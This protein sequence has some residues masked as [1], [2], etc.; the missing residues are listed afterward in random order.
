MRNRWLTLAALVAGA[1][2]GAAAL[3]PASATDPV[4]LEAGYVTDIA[5]VLE[6]SE[7]QAAEDRLL[8]LSTESDASLFVVFVDE[9][10]SPSDRIAWADTVARDN[11]LGDEQYLLAVAVEQGVYYIS[12]GAGGPISDAQLDDIEQ[13]IQP[14]LSQSDWEGAVIL[15]ADE[16]QGD[17]GA[18]L[19]R[20]VLIVAGIV[21]AALV[22]WL[23]VR[24]II[25]A[26]RNAEIRRRGAMPE[27]P[28]PNDP[29][30]TLTDEQV[31]A[32]AGSAIVQADDAI[33]SS[34]E[35]LGFAVAQFGEGV[36]AQFSSVL[37]AAKAKM[38]EVFDLKQKLDD[39]IED[40]VH[41]RRAWHIRIIRLCDE[42]DEM[43]DQNTEAFDELRGLA[44]N[45]P[46]ELERVKRERAALQPLLDGAQPELQSLS[47]SYDADALSTVAEN[48]AQA[49]ERAV[50]AD[51][52]I[53]A[54]AS[55][56]EAGR[57]GEAAFAIRTAEQA[58]AQAA[59]LTRA[60]ASLAGELGSIESQAHELIAE[61]Q[62]DVAASAQLPDAGGVIAA[63][64]AAATQQ[65]QQAQANL[66][67]TAR[68]PQ[69]ML[70]AL[71]AADAQIDAA[72]AEG[73]ETV[74]QAQRAQ[75][76]LD[77]TIAQ[78]N[79]EI[80]AT[81]DLIETRRGV[82]GPTARTR[83][84]MAEEALTQAI[85]LAPTSQ[86][87]ARSA[88]DRARQLAAQAAAS[89]RADIEAANP[90]RY[91][92][93]WAGGWG[94]GPFGS[95]SGSG[96]S[97]LA[98]DILGGIIGGLLSGAGGSRSSG[99]SNWRSSGGFRSSGFGGGG[100]SGGR[101]GRSGGGRF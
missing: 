73:Q 85:G 49:R 69:R 16:M 23:V 20:G 53:A 59:Q 43:L 33:T 8:E 71:T 36:T 6:P 67:G 72:I 30:S 98:G 77:Q 5:G 48:P 74:R 37:E 2:M 17:G 75:R 78:A 27:K 97:G 39:E 62:R 7:K 15:A 99:R 10:T 95:S 29:F 88:A 63:A 92:D 24:L 45:A 79:S 81:R 90:N 19:L 21:V 22:V 83:L 60:I 18:G 80:R 76:M 38:A 47:S 11:N 13:K 89:A 87:E 65:L 86:S 57:T 42:I 94:G 14:L 31:E 64:A 101:S 61:L 34:R 58:V 93:R 50:L 40:T 70:E 46:V 84:S 91:D 52:S 9:F 96:G 68:N 28:D 41:D 35:E 56:I 66:S 12:A 4:D 1:L 100:R 55:A 26:R 25:R 54:A 3:S 32:Q 82:I 51:R 44:T